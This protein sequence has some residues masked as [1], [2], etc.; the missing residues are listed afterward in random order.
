M[1]G[2]EIID[3][4]FAAKFLRAA[5]APLDYGVYLLFHDWWAE[6]PQQAIEAYSRELA[7]I[8]EAGSL[9]AS[10]YIS[11][12]LSLDRLAECAPGTLGH[13]YRRFILDNKLEQNLGRNY[14][15][16]N[17]ELT[18]SGKLDRLPPD[19][20]YMMVRG[21]Q[22]HDFLHVLTG[23]EATNWGELALAAFYLA[24]LRFPYHAMR[25]AVTAAHMAFVRPGL[26]VD[27]MDAFVD[28]WSY[29]RTARNLNFERW[30]DELD[31]P[32]E[33]LRARMNLNRVGLA[34]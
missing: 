8:P 27:A 31:T 32:L 21:F 26:I 4:E 33:V 1:A 24:Q 30:E 28:G 19:L 3:R 15:K 9:L 6:A 18:S 16:F 22:I 20:S 12:P 7:S 11:E 25:V 14:R 5:D 23:Y 13:A 10:R 34:A 29:G 17:E 2:A